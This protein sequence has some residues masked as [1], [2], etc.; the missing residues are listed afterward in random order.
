MGSE[1][2]I[3]MIPDVVTTIRNPTLISMTCSPG[4]SWISVCKSILKYLLPSAALIVSVIFIRLSDCEA[5]HPKAKVCRIRS[6]RDLE[7]LG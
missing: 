3:P 5:Q 1:R 2:V 4:R 7:A 6:R